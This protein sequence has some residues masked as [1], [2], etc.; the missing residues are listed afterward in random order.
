MPT[1]PLPA[2]L[3]A[4][5]SANPAK[6]V[7]IGL[8]LDQANS[9]TWKVTDRGQVREFRGMATFDQDVMAFSPPDQPPMVG[10]VTWNDDR[11]FSI[12][13]ARCTTE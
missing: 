5:W 11:R 8:S 10:T 13:G 4:S 6:D 7:T 3:V 1:G 9:F 12:Q 2:K